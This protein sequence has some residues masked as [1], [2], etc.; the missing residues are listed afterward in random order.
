MD[1]FEVVKWM[2]WKW[3]TSRGSWQSETNAL[4]KSFK[5]WQQLQGL[6]YIYSGPQIISEQKNKYIYIYTYSYRERNSFRTILEG[7][8]LLWDVEM[9]IATK[10]QRPR[11]LAEELDP[12][13][14]E[15]PREDE[16]SDYAPQRGE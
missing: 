7:I 16:M 2:D 5:Q 10:L 6:I 1:R 15:K 8:H 12:M 3:S 4:R 9:F 14:I 11:T 13:S